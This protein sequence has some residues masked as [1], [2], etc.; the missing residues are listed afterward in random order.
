[1][2]LKY[3]TVALKVKAFMRA[4]TGQAPLK[5]IN[6]VF[7]GQIFLIVLAL[8]VSIWFTIDLV[9]VALPSDAFFI[10]YSIVTV[11][12]G[13]VVLGILVCGLSMFLKI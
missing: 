9:Y 4:D 2:N 6:F 8:V 11:L 1:V 10:F 5:M 13:Y 7:V 3:L 12:P